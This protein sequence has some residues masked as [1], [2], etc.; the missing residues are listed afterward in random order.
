MFKYEVKFE[1]KIDIDGKKHKVFTIYKHF[2]YSE[3]VKNTSFEIK[4]D[5]DMEQIANYL[6]I[7]LNMLERFTPKELL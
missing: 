3:V 7:S 1:E 2:D 5:P 6:T 4:D